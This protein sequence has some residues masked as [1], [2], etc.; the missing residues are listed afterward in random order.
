MSV[1]AATP[2]GP[3]PDD[4]A[5]VR[6]CLSAACTQQPTSSSSGWW[7]IASIA[8]RPTPPVAH[9]T[10]RIRLIRPTSAAG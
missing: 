2:I 5:D 7:R 3:M 6:P 9:W 1:V 4:L 10:T 8:A